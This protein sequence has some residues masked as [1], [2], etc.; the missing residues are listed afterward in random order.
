MD[1]GT[2][3]FA[4]PYRGWLL[5]GMAMTLLL[6]AVTSVL[7]LMGGFLVANLG[8]SRSRAARI[9]AST[10]VEVFRSLPPVPLLLFLVLALPGAFAS[11]T[12]TPMP[13][14]FEYPLLVAGLSL[15]A[16]AYVAEALRSGLRALP[17]SQ[18][19]SC[20]VLGLG[21]IATRMRVVWPQALRVCLP[22]L[23]NRI[24]HNVKNTTVALVIPLT[25]DRTEIL[26]QAARVAG[27]TFAWAEPLVVAAAFHLALALSLGL[28]LSA[29]AR[30]ARRGF[31][32]P[33]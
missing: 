1:F 12:G 8:S 20:R 31:E 4:E 3:V 28:L 26:G 14:G 19:D 24:I 13:R 11:L 32:V 18:W 9:A 22:A 27:E 7:A 21:P 25:L 5:R 23:G 17:E 6:G 16:S 33:R 30:R 15:N 10:F 29:A 2:Y